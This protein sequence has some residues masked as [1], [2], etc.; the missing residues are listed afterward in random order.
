MVNIS[1]LSSSMVVS[2]TLNHRVLLRCLSETLRC[3][4]ET[5]QCLSETL[6]CLSETLRCL[7]EVEGT[8][9]YIFIFYNFCN[10][11]YSYIQLKHEAHQTYH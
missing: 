9:L 7:S 2:A 8:T 1:A 6:R 4:S 10:E 11:Y 3:L 5:L